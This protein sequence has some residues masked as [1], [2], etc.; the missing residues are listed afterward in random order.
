MMVDYLRLSTLASI[1][2]YLFS[3]SILSASDRDLP[4]VL[5]AD[6]ITVTRDRVIVASGNVEAFQGKIRLTASRV[7]YDQKTSKLMV[8]GPITIQDEEGTLILANQAELSRD[9]QNGLLQGARLV[10][11]EQLQ[12]ASVQMSRV[13]GRYTQLYK[14][15]VTSC[16]ICEEDPS[17]PL[18][19]IRAKRVIHDMENK[20]LYFDQ[21]QF[22]VLGIP[23]VYLPSLRLP[24]PTVER[25]S[26][27]LIPSILTSS[28]LGLG[29]KVP[30]FIVLNKKSDLT[31]A[32]YLSSRTKTLE[33]RY[34]HVFNRGYI[35]FQGALSDD[36]LESGMRGY[37]SGVGQ[38]KLKKDFVLDFNLEWVSDDTYLYDYDFSNTDRL[39]SILQLSR[40]Q[41][42]EYIELS[43]LNFKSLRDSDKNNELPNDAIEAVYQKRFFPN[44]IGGELRLT[45]LGH[46][47]FRRSQQSLDYD[48]NDVAEGR[49][50]LRFTVEAEWLKAYRLGGLQIQTIVRAA[51]DT[52]DIKQDDNYKG[53]Y[54][55]I[56]PA[57]S[58]ILRYPLSRI[59]NEATQIIEPLAQVGWVGGDGLAIPNEESISVDFDEGNLLSLSRFPAPDRR[60]R[61]LSLA[62]GAQWSH[63]AYD[64]WSA[65]ILL[66]Q[67]LRNNS[68]ADFTKSSG[69][70]STNSDILLSGQ[71]KLS[72]SIYF[73]GRTIF[74]NDFEFTKSEV[75]GYWNSKTFNFGGSYV[76]LDKD[77]A[78][79][80]L[81][82]INELTVGASYQLNRFWN[83]N[84]DWRYDLEAD[85]SATAGAGLKYS[86]ECVDI[87]LSIN[88]RYTTSTTVEPSTN[89]GLTM[90]LNG[91][92]ASTGAQTL[93]RSCGKRAK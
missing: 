47:H 42:D 3:V 20:Q 36:V 5:V 14:A 69:L 78:E 40:A 50:V 2:I 29:I 38:F 84:I 89:L 16:R 18:W 44:P 21:A 1:L 41:R 92:S 24:D 54:S 65:N 55:D 15:V 64:G 58:V 85:R 11:N 90:S 31:I 6:E 34:R 46:T 28:R 80:R 43:Y 45:A 75:K 27:F 62:Y 23:I 25:T 8:T 39:D 76:W 93:T 60:E 91:L 73:A 17:P 61:G 77:P 70:S 81:S 53:K 35:E 74:D 59:V 67:I 9:M 82:P 68:Q 63:K 30:Y 66:A 33:F 56:V 83:L 32:P 48:S 26:G 10:L 13:D 87:A 71:F 52:F 12:L 37:T 22:R 88:R 51:A 57:T 19:Q 72:K 4:A 7:S 49:D 86:N 79:D